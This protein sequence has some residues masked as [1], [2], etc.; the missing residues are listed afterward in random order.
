MNPN[1]LQL[2]ALE[3]SNEGILEDYSKAKESKIF[4]LRFSSLEELNTIFNGTTQLMTY[5][6]VLKTYF[7]KKALFEH[8][9]KFIKSKKID[10]EFFVQSQNT[11]HNKLQSYSLFKVQVVIK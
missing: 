10:F 1:F 3:A 6:D 11:D 7:E 4:S 5:D 9:N 2:M 8:Q